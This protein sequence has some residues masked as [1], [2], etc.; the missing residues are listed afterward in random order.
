MPERFV[1]A[2]KLKP[3]VV[4]PVDYSRLD[5]GHYLCVYREPVAELIDDAVSSVINRIYQVSRGPD[6]YKR[7]LKPLRVPDVIWCFGTGYMLI[8]DGVYSGTLFREAPTPCYRY[9]GIYVQ[10]VELDPRKILSQCKE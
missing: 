1:Y 8:P 9:E 6:W 3:N 10:E 7:G 5:E 2:F 4:E